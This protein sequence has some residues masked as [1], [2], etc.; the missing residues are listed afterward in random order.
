MAQVYVVRSGSS[1]GG[2]I[3]TIN[4]KRYYATRGK[5][6]H[7][8]EENLEPDELEILD[9]ALLGKPIYTPLYLKCCCCPARGLLLKELEDGSYIDLMLHSGKLYAFSLRLCALKSH[10]QCVHSAY[11]PI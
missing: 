9:P 11:L 6:Q 5:K 7:P 3:Y 10:H 1:R 4:G 2:V 8:I